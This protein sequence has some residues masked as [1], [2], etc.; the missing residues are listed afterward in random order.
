[1]KVFFANRQLRQ[2]FEDYNRAERIWGVAVAR[3]YIQRVGLIMN[4]RDFNY[5][6]R[7]PS[8]RLHPLS[9][10]LTGRFAIDLNRS[11]RLILT[12]DEDKK[13]VRILEVTNHYE[14]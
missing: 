10:P 7:I 3:K 4:A 14:D 2:C 8:L 13:S 11:W 9:G 12:H 1:M 5:L 6:R